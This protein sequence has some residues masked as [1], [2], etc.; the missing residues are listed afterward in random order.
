MSDE[1]FL[2]YPLRKLY[3]LFPDIYNSPSLLASKDVSADALYFMKQDVTWIEGKYQERDK[4]NLPKLTQCELPDAPLS[5]SLSI[6]NPFKLAV[7]SDHL[8]PYDNSA[9]GGTFDKL[10]GGHKVLLSLAALLP[11]SK[12][13]I[14]LI[15]DSL[16]VKKKHAEAVQSYKT[17][18][19]N[20]RKFFHYLRPSIEVEVRP[21]LDS[22]GLAGTVTD[23]NALL[24][25]SETLPGGKMVQ[26]T[27]EQNKLNPL[28]MPVLQFDK[29]EEKISSTGVRT[30][31]V[32]KAQVDLAKMKSQWLSLTSAMKI[33]EATAK[34]WWDVLLEHYTEDWRHYHTLKHIHDILDLKATFVT[35]QNPLFDL[36]IWFH[37]IVYYPTEKDNEEQSAELF[38]RFALEAGVKDGGHVEELIRATKEHKGEREDV[39]LMLDLDLEVLGREKE[40]YAKYA[41]GVRKEY[42]CYPDADYK[43]G[44][45]MVLNAF[46]KNETIFLTPE[47]IKRYEAR[48]RDN[49]QQEIKLIS[50]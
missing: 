3:F 8:F 5:H 22:V 18:E 21:L 38:K 7:E 39:R 14:G 20:I 31:I 37:D 30:A 28:S 35:P 4:L 32:N 24:I 6:E 29:I 11:K 9:V 26:A 50:S 36:A 43:K 41:E 44:R 47:A 49:I 33:S 25:T 40:E 16:L 2:N 46:L 48:A 45:A 13:Y 17:R 10:H 12:L 27:R 19:S 1:V 42:S 34:K 15:D 23:L